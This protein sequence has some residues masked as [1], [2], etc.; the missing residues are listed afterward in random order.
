MVRRVWLVV[1]FFMVGYL[2][3]SAQFSAQ[4]STVQGSGRTLQALQPKIDFSMEELYAPAAMIGS[5]VLLDLSSGMKNTQLSF[6]KDHLTHFQTAADNYLLYVP[7]V[8]PYGLDMVGI[9]SKTDIL[10]RTAILIKAE[11]LVA[12]TGFALKHSIHEWRPDHS[13]HYSFPSGHSLQVFATA[14]M[15][16]EEYKDRF[17]W[18]PY[19]AYGFASGVGL[20]RIAN[21]KHYLGDVLVGAGL[22][23]LSMKVAYWTHH[24]K[25]G[26]RSVK[27]N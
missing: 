22:G 18:M 14:T 27:F 1:C 5:G 21:N 26:K 15:L 13:N 24:Y 16:S 6:H 12:A 20:L 8:I 9:P 19:A 11:V 17:S 10:N 2:P 4:D 3:V 25:W 23:V 7:A